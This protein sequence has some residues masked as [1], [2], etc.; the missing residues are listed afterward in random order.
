MVVKLN[1][2]L[3][4]QAN[5][6][7]KLDVQVT[8]RDL[9]ALREQTLCNPQWVH[10]G[11]GNLYRGFHAEVAQE[12]INQ[13]KLETGVIVCETYDENIIDEAYLPYDNDILEV[14]MHE[15]GTLEKKLLQS[16]VESYYCNPDRPESYEAVKAIFENASLQFATFTITEKGYGL[17]DINGNY[18]ALVEKDI[19]EGPDSAEHTMAIVASLL[20]ARFNAGQLPIAMVTTDNFSQNGQKFQ[21][22][23]LDIAKGWVAQNH[24]PQAFVDYLED[25]NKVSFPWSMI[26]RITP[27]PSESVKTALELEGFEGVE[28][29]HTPKH[30]NIAPFANTEV[31]HYLVVEDAFPNG[32]PELEA[33]GVILTD[34][35]T[36]DKADTMKVTTCLNP[37]HTALAVFGNLLGFT[38]I[39]GEMADADLVALV[40]QVGYVEGLPVVVNP[41]IIDPKAFI[42]EV[43]TKR[44]VNANIPDTPQRIA[45][46]TSQKVA[47]R[48]GETIKKYVESDTL[49]GDNLTFI[50]LTLAAWVRY[51][52]GV[53]DNGESFAI[54]PDPLLADLQAQ[55]SGVNLGFTGNLHDKVAPILANDKIFGLDLY[56][57]G[58]GEKIEGYLAELLVGPGA[59]RNTL[60][61]LLAE[62]K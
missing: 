28:L 44:L 40:K 55:L 61:V 27:N 12:L 7:D 46:D 15:D 30:T 18:T 41:G 19:A 37:L 20:L 47:I 24:A 13:G 62:K 33:A 54:S 14:I 25:S 16:T 11:G 53:D 21:T 48:F 3:C 23:I 1:K 60:H 58:L 26:D 31:S 17:T 38:S 22:S 32:R 29:I 36:V 42:D 6:L 34:R 43:V 50:P 35:D 56:A 2:S 49:S 9:S 57:A 8:K 39:S 52:L 51:L 4:L 10:F 45:S 5:E 59:V